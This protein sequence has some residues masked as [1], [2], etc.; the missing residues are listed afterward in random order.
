MHRRVLITGADG[1]IGSH[2]MEHLLA[3]TDWDLV[4][5]CSFTKG[6]MS[7]RITTSAH[8]QRNKHRVTV[9]Y[10]DLRGPIDDVTRMLIGEDCD[11]VIHFAAASHVDTSIEAPVPFVTNNV[12]VTLNM[13]EWARRQPALRIFIQIST[14]EVYGPAPAGHAHAEWE[15]IIPSNPYAASKAMQEAAGI[16]WWRTYG[17]P[18]VIGQAMNCIGERQHPEKFVPKIIRA[19]L[20]GEPVTVHAVREGDRWVSGSRYYLHARNY[21]DACK[22]LIERD[23]ASAYNA[24]GREPPFAD[25]PDR[26]NVVGD[27]EIANDEL[28]GMIAGMMGRPP[29]IQYV[30][31]HSARPGHDLRYALDGSKIAKAGWT[32]PVAFEESLRRTVQWYLDN[33]GWLGLGGK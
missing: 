14:D 12:A 21:A 32:A 6:G 29:L 8:Y 18:V 26:W 3:T 17:V 15:P 27:V 22:W 7:P 11:A 2:A 5:L 30:D 1:F 28:V 31:A 16:G 19:L 10:H 13:L 4:L 20:R 33:P 24:P 25:R 9:L 23:T